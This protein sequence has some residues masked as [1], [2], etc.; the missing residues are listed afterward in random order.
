M[1]REYLSAAMKRAKYEMLSDDGTYYGEIP[2][3]QG[4]LANAPDLEECRNQLE[5]V[6]EEWLLFRISRGLSVPVVD[7]ID[8]M[9]K[10]VVEL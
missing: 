5:E 3:F 6:L 8:L 10:E 9:F 7:G 4:V 1:F 2:G